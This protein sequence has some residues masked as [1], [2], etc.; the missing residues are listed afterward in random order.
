MSAF[1]AFIVLC[2]APWLVFYTFDLSLNFNFNKR[3]FLIP[4]PKMSRTG[5]QWER[6]HCLQNILYSCSICT[7]PVLNNWIYIIYIWL[8]IYIY[9]CSKNKFKCHSLRKPPRVKGDCAQDMAWKSF[10]C[11][12]E[13]GHHAWSA[14]MTF[15]WSALIPLPVA[16]MLQD[17]VANG[18]LFVPSKRYP[19]HTKIFT[20]GQEGSSKTHFQGHCHHRLSALGICASVY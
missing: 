4:P 20:L 9:I 10:P 6:H 13:E 18:H 12:K 14:R 16:A 15:R 11:M 2:S 17:L 3:L 8:H 1:D 7:M 19:C 5:L